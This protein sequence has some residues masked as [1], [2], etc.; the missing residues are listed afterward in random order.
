MV[1]RENR[2]YDEISVGDEAAEQRVL[3]ADGMCIFAHASGNQNPLNLPSDGGIPFK[4][5]G[6]LDVDRR[7]HILFA[8]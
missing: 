3:S 5:R 6:A 1:L 4:C 8:A 2:T 7:A